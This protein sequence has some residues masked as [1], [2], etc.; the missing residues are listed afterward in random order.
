MTKKVFKALLALSFVCSDSGCSSSCIRNT[1]CTDGY[2]CTAGSC[3][4]VV[5]VEG[6]SVAGLTPAP[7]ESL[8]VDTAMPETPGAPEAGSAADGGVP[9]P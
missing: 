3:V 2:Q 6:G 8:P 5:H 1:D 9:V 7:S 4:M